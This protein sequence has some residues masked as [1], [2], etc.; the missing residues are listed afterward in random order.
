MH[1]NACMRNSVYREG[2]REGEREENE[3][4][5]KEGEEGNKRGRNRKVG[6]KTLRS[7]NSSIL[8]YLIYMNPR[9][10]I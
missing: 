10:L 5:G 8:P 9:P 1:V 2:G 3:G 6:I 7:Y 4:G